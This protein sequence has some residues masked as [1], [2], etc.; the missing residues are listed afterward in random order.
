[1]HRSTSPKANPGNPGLSF[2]SEKAKGGTLGMGKYLASR[3]RA[4]YIHVLH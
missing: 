4:W 2:S 1:M 3:K